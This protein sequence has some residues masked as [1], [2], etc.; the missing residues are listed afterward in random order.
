MR[1]RHTLRALWLGVG[2]GALTLTEAYASPYALFW[3]REHT[4]V[5]DAADGSLYR[6]PKLYAEGPGGVLFEYRLETHSAAS[7]GERGEERAPQD[8]TR[9]YGWL[10]RWMSLERYLVGDTGEQQDPQAQDDKLLN[11]TLTSHYPPEQVEGDFNDE[12]QI[13]QFTGERVTLSRWVSQLK[14]GKKRANRSLYTIDLANR[15]TLSQLM[16]SSELTQ[17]TRE[18]FPRLIPSC[19]EPTRALIHWELAAQRSTSWL[20]LLPGNGSQ[21]S[22]CP[23]SGALRV[24][25]PVGELSAGTLRWE[26]LTGRLIES[27]EPI[28]GGVV[29]VLLHPS[30]DIAL[31]LEGAKR[32]QEEGLFVRDP[33]GF[34]EAHISRALS[35]WRRRGAPRLLTMPHLLE[36]QRLDGARWIP[37]THPILQLLQTH[38]TNLETRSCYQRLRSHRVEK[39]H[40]PP[41]P[42]L[43]AHI[44]RIETYGRLWGG[45]EDLSAQVIATQTSRTLFIDLW[46][47]DSKR[48]NGDMVTLWVGPAEAPIELKIKQ[49]EVIA[50]PGVSDQV[51]ARWT[52]GRLDP[53]RAPQL[54]KQKAQMMLIKRLA[55]NEAPERGYLVSVEL[56]LSLVQGGLS[57]AVQDVDSAKGS[58]SVKLW[59][60]GEPSKGY[61]AVVPAPI[62]VQ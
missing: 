50:P 46:V 55:E 26:P 62:E 29:D 47:R 1:V 56:P 54:S 45:V 60:V 57:L 16:E 51:L 22:S 7:G 11:T 20:L 44:C 39:Y 38:F 6:A 23:A 10:Y 30:G 35:L 24:R 18:L 3:S 21:R 53:K 4:W 58:E 13:L 42:E 28:L 5:L 52:E 59:V 14:D 19:L 27:G 12:H 25:P 31:L 32:S 41:T 33:L 49:R 40:R 34:D 9:P 17:L 37:D 61:E 2:L 15:Q 36:L 43:S 8:T 48:S